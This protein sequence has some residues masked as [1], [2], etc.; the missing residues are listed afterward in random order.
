MIE[1][2]ADAI[3]DLILISYIIENNLI[4]LNVSLTQIIQNKKKN[5]CANYC[6]D[7]HLS[8]YLCTINVELDNIRSAP[9]CL[10]DIE[11]NSSE[12][13]TDLININD[14]L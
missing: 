12:S 10:G 6:V 14:K 7:N 9:L 2:F 4:S 13:T 1:H 5:V 11:T 3:N 8:I